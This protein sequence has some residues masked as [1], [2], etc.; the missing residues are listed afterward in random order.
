M[1]R[2]HFVGAVSSILGIV[3]RYM[4][5]QMNEAVKVAIQIQYD[6]LRDE[7]QKENDEFLKTIDEN[8]QKIIKEQV[9]KQVKVQVSKILLKIEQ[10]VNEQLEAEV[11]TRSSNSS[12]TSYAVAADLSKMELK[13]ILIEKIEGNKS[14][15]RSIEQRN[16]Y[17]ALV[18]AYESDKIILDIYG[19]TVTLKRRRD[20]DADKDEEP[21]VK[22]DRGSKRRREGKEPESASDPK[23]KATRSAGKST[24]GS[25]SRQTSASE[26]ATAEEPMQTTFEMEEPSHPEFETGADDQPIVEPSQHPEWFSQQKKPPTPDRDWNK[27]LSTTHESI[28]PWI[29][30][31]AKQSNSCSS[32]NELMDT[33]VDFSNFLMNRLKVDT[34]TPELIDGP[35]YK[36]MKGSCKSLV[37][38]EFFLEEVYKA[39]TDQLDWVNPKGQQYPHNLLKPLPLIPDSQGR[40]VIPFDHFINN[41]LEYLRGCASSHKYTTS[42]TKKKAADYGHIKWIEDLVP[43]TMWIQ[44]PVGYDK[45]ALWGISYWGRKR[46]QFYSFVVNWES[47]RDVYSKRRIIAVTKLKIVEWHNYKHLYW[48]TVRIDD[49]KLYKFKEGDFKRLRIQYIEDMLL[50]LVQGKLTNLTVEE[51]FAFNKKLNLT[52]PDTYRSDLKRKEAYNAY[53]NPRGFIYQNKDKKNR[54][55]LI[56][57]LHK[58]SDGTL[59]DVRTALDDRLKWIRMKYLP[60]SFWRKSDKDRA[61]AMI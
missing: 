25:K 37:E 61:A 11:L 13:K 8:M 56:D 34:L 1:Q 35:T 46:Q 2:N 39:T 15:Q 19:D 21:S 42:V 41:D 27:T 28:Q 14:I 23:E 31:L 10:T 55:M 54:L 47:A 50:L 45:H 57:E 3:Q 9:K 20:D 30:E 6:R 18:K 16:L 36:L 43:R 7:A 59:T 5:Q 60:K 58:F 32:F 12:K 52:R 4:D 51:R 53:S 24:Q 49:D 33:P 22:S 40:R 38:L 26:S 17:K 48:I 29:S 44:E